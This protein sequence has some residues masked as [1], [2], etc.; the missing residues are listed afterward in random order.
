CKKRLTPD[1]DSGY[2]PMTGKSGHALVRRIERYVDGHPLYQDTNN[3][4]KDFYE[5]DACSLR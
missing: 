1:L 4:S 2:V 5:T 3:S